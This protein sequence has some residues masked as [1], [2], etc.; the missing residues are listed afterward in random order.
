MFLKYAVCEGEKKKDKE[1]KV[2][3]VKW[4]KKMSK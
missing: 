2:V 3:G 1:D 4:E